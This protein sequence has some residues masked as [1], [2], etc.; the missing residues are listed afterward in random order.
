MIY[1]KKLLKIYKILL[2]EYGPQYWWPADSPFEVMIGAV[3]T[4]NTNW[5]NVSRAIENLKEKNL[6]DPQRIASV[7]KGKLIT[8]IRPSGFYN[9]KAAYLKG[10]SRYVLERFSGDLR[11]MPRAG[12][13]VLRDELLAVKGLGPETV[14]S[15]LLYALN[16]PVFVIDAYT[17]R[18]FGRH[19]V[20]IN[21][22]DYSGWQKFF[23]SHLPKDQRLFNEYHALIVRLAK[24]R[25]RQRPDCQGCPLEGVTL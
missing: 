25:C 9:Q 18:I 20:Q 2:K 4:Q 13:G 11:K 21:D 22:P 12:T 7:D 1:G 24:E 5:R 15:I 14:D 16:Q 23:E 17:R 8:A 6:I 19:G 10:L 3:L